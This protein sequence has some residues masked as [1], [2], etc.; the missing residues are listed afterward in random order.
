MM[1]TNGK[2][3]AGMLRARELAKQ[4]ANGM[5]TRAFAVVLARQEFLT[6]DDIAR[7][8]PNLPE[9]TAQ[10]Y[11]QAFFRRYKAGGWLSMTSR[12]SKSERSSKPLIV[13]KNLRFK[14]G[15]IA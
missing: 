14:K 5:L 7:E 9:G 13:W 15:A 12:F 8:C 4:Q 3:M 11:C 1:E 6:A 10:R 2:D